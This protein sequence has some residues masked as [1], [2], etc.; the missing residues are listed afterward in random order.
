[1]TLDDLRQREHFSYSS[2]NQFFNICSLQWAFLRVYNVKPSF[3]PATLSFGSAF[4]RVMEHVSTVRKEKGVPNK[5]D[6]CD[7]FQD[8]WERQVSEDENIRFDEDVTKE[9]CGEQGRGMVACYVDSIDPVERVLAVN[10]TFAVPVAGSDKPLIGELDLVVEKNGRQTV[11]DWKTSGR[12]WPKDKAEK[13]LQPT[14][15]LYAYEQ[16]HGIL[17]EFR[18]DVV[19]KNKTPV[20]E[21]HITTRTQDHFQ[22]FTRLITLMESMVRHEHFYPSEQGFY[23]NGCPFADACKAWH[24][25]K[26]K[27]I[28]VGRAA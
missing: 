14:A 18:F 11:I 3:T 7:L 19:V 4:H 17:P 1:M 28:N 21:Q 12:R 8:L 16:T 5:Q 15:I 22:R 9:T 13:D 2:I 23:C 6:A 25:Q 24:R 10:E 20:F 27:V 26:Q